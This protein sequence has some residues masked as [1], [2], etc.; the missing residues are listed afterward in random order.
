MKAKVGMKVI[1]STGFGY[2]ILEVTGRTAN[3]IATR[4]LN[5]SPRDARAK[6]FFFR[7]SDSAKSARLLQIEAQMK[8]LRDEQRELYRSLELLE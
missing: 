7:V 3:T 4:H 1:T 8:E 6:L 5:G 2:Y